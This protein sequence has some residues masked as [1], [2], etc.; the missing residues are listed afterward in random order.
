MEW[1]EMRTPRYDFTN[2][3]SAKLR[4]D[5]SFAR[6]SAPS[7]RSKASSIASPSRNAEMPQDA[8]TDTGTGMT[9][10]VKARLFEL[11]KLMEPEAAAL[12]AERRSLE[13]L[14]RMGMALE[15]MARETLHTVEGRQADNSLKPL[16]KANIDTGMGLERT[17]AVLQGVET[18]YHSDILKPIVLA[19]GDIC[20]VKYDPAGESG[21]RLRRIAD[22][23][24]ACTFAIHEN[25]YPGPNKEKYVIKRLLRR[26]VLDGHELGQMGSVSFIL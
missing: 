4:F 16:P 22:H 8:V 3:A 17:A 20:G 25:V 15:I 2:V 12:A 18:N 11:R 14:N 6:Y 19:A 9:E 7:A 26:A 23:V 13:Q 1:D 5:V 10:E 21:R 24:R